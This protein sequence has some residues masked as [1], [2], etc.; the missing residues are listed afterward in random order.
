MLA[1]MMKETSMII[2]KKW[3]IYKINLEDMPENELNKSINLLI[4]SR[5]CQT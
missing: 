3:V 1:F 2:K 4:F 5:F